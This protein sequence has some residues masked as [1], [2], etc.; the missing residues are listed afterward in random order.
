MS[1][2]SR[3][4]RPT[5]GGTSLKGSKGRGFPSLPRP[6]FISRHLRG[7]R[8]NP[9]LRLGRAEYLRAFHPP[10]DAR[11]TA[12]IRSDQLPHGG[13]GEVDAPG[14]TLLLRRGTSSGHAPKKRPVCAK[15]KPRARAGWHPRTGRQ[16][17]AVLTNDQ[18]PAIPQSSGRFPS[19]L[20]QQFGYN[21][22]RWDENHET[23][24]MPE[25]GESRGWGCSVDQSTRRIAPDRT[26]AHAGLAAQA[27]WRTT[28]GLPRVAGFPSGSHTGLE[29]GTCRRP[30]MI[31]GPKWKNRR[32]VA[33]KAPL[34]ATRATDGKPAPH[35]PL[36][37][38]T[39]TRKAA[40]WRP[41]FPP[42]QRAP[43][44]RVFACPLPP[45]TG[46]KKRENPPVGTHFASNKNREGL[47]AP[48]TGIRR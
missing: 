34:K 45:P 7:G 13:W 23:N 2:R 41:L 11:T 48:F 28:C 43:L 17:F 15:S 36:R 29:C 44:L 37:W 39:K 8:A 46:P 1:V 10:T 19:K 40:S 33:Q 38:G 5:R 12:P 22:P 18:P 30:T 26:R 14:A 6:S 31:A 9:W 16:R 21:G 42:F 25:R 20:G 24:E 35:F 32:L 4:V 3:M 27:G 47:S